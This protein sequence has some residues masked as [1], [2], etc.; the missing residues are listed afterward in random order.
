MPHPIAPQALPCCGKVGG[1]GHSGVREIEQIVATLPKRASEGDGQLDGLRIQRTLL[2]FPEAWTEAHSRSWL[3]GNTVCANQLPS[4]AA[5]DTLM[6]C[7]RPVLV[8][9]ARRSFTA[10]EKSI[11]A[12]VYENIQSPSSVE[13]PTSREPSP[14][15]RPT[16]PPQPP[17]HGTLAATMPTLSVACTSTP[18]ATTQTAARLPVLTVSSPF[19]GSWLYECDC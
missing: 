15:S 1:R 4:G 14:L 16:S 9:A 3:F 7:G 2:S 19:A 17:S 12:N 6:A 13:T 8:D 10:S 11:I 5:N 18:L